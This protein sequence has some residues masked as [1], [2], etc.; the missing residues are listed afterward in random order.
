MSRA[1]LAVWD[2]DSGGGNNGDG[3]GDGGDGGGGGVSYVRSKIKS[4]RKNLEL[5]K[6]IPGLEM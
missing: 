2:G 1:P 6:N 4:I 5:K 3:G